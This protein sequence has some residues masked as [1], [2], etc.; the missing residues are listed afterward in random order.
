MIRVFLE[1]NMFLG[2]KSNRSMEANC[3]LRPII[4]II[5]KSIKNVLKVKY[6]YEFGVGDA[7]VCFIFTSSCVLRPPDRRF[8]RLNKKSNAPAEL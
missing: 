5:N 3:L 6:V 1:H 7:V 4:L 2:V 8:Q